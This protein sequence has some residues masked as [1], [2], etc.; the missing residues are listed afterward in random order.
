ML[1]PDQINLK[2]LL[3][4]LEG[5]TK[6]LHSTKQSLNA[7]FFIRWG[8]TPTAIDFKIRLR[9]LKSVAKEIM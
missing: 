3:V 6:I 5:G 8:K 1:L 9:V 2:I 7:I 4:S